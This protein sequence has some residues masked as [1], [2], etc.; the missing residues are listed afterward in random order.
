[1]E[2]HPRYVTTLVLVQVSGLAIKDEKS[3]AYLHR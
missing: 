3:F 1:M 2:E